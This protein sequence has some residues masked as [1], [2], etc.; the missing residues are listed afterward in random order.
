HTHRETH[1][2]T[3]RH[4]QTHTD[5]HKRE[6][7]HTDTHRHRHTQTHTEEHR[8]TQTHTDTQRRAQTQNSIENNPDDSSTQPVT[9][10]Y[11]P[12]KSLQCFWIKITATLTRIV[13]LMWPCNLISEGSALPRPLS[14]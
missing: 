13:F 8:H 3:H 14:S 4:T 12:N 1:T 10:T 2:D 7:T 9:E 11:G 5:T 6:Q